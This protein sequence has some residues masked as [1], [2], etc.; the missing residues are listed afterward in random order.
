MGSLFPQSMGIGS[1][2]DCPGYV[3]RIIRDVEVD[4]RFGSG[5][6]VDFLKSLKSGHSGCESSAVIVVGFAFEEPGFR[7]IS[8]AAT[9]AV[10]VRVSSLKDRNSTRAPIA[11]TAAESLEWS[12]CICLRAARISFKVS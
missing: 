11:S 6:T 12:Y 1:I 5:E 10:A 3:V 9:L 7:W 2:P 4:L 8:F